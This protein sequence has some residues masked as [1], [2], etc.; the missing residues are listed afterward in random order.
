MI[1]GLSDRLRLPRRG[2][3]RLGEK[4]VSEKSGKEYPVSLDYF[5]VPDEVKSIYGAKPRK[6]DIMLPME[7]RESFFPQN[8]KR[9]GSSA[10]LLCRGNGEVA[11]E[12]DTEEMKE[13]ECLGK[14]CEW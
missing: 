7:N 13:V 14:D 1:K 4:K 11:T 6:L 2:K 9:Y 8:Y 10:G 3:I 12:M 5:V